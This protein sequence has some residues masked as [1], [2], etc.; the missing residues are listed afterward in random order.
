MHFRHFELAERHFT[1]RTTSNA[2]R[3]KER[4]S[5]CG[6]RKRATGCWM[7][8]ATN[9]QSESDTKRGGQLG[10][11][12]MLNKIRC[13]ALPSVYRTPGCAYAKRN[14]PSALYTAFQ[15][16]V[17]MIDI[18]HFSW[19]ILGNKWNVLLD[20]CPWT[21]KAILVTCFI[22]NVDIG[23]TCH[24]D[25]KHR[26]IGLNNMWLRSL[27]LICCQFPIQEGKLFYYFN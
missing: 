21:L 23:C 8:D 2:E 20:I 14:F 15:K 17:Y 27:S 3:E 19:R 7:L 4:K 26:W 1:I 18:C 25:I 11:T 6:D 5:A 10:R 12:A 13:D 16:R 24:V 9:A 22:L